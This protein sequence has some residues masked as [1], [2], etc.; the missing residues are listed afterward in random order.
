[1]LENI[2]VGIK[3]VTL[4]QIHVLVGYAKVRDSSYTQVI[5]CVDTILDHIDTKTI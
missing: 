1:M 2:P 3:I 5:T 4:N